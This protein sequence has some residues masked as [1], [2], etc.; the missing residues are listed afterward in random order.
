MV[1]LKDRLIGRRAEASFGRIVNVWLKISD[2]TQQIVGSPHLP[3]WKPLDVTAGR[4]SRGPCPLEIEAA[5][6]A[7]DV[8][9]FADEIKPGNRA[10]LECLLG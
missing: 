5:E 2:R 7:G 8:D 10:G 4:M 3:R 1:L 9:D 6:M